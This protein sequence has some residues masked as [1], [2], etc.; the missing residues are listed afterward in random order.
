MDDADLMG[1]ILAAL[2]SDTSSQLGA[3]E[4]AVAAADAN[5]TVRLAHYSKGACANVGA[6]STARILQEIEKRAAAGDLQACS[7]SLRSLETEFQKLQDEAAGL[8]C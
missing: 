1:E 2:I 4:R 8:T 6:T 5:E 3:L 7:A